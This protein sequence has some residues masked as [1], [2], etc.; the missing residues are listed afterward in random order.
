[1]A[2]ERR[3][4]SGRRWYGEGATK[5]AAIGDGLELGR[6]GF[7]AACGEGMS[8]NALYGP[9]MIHYYTLY[10]HYSTNATRT[11]GRLGATARG[12]QRPQE[13]RQ[14]R[15][16]HGL[17]PVRPAWSGR[18]PPNVKSYSQGPMS[19]RSKGQS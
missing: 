7:D 13:R 3:D 17:G 9:I 11:R 2:S 4:R 14:E 10:I 19:L 12:H 6:I 16:H 1:M 18:N 15:P 5:D 8:S